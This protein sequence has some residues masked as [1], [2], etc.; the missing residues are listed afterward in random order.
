MTLEDQI[1]ALLLE[2]APLR[3][4][5]EMEQGELGAIV[6]RI[7][8]LREKQ[9]KGDDSPPITDEAIE[10]GFYV[11][12]FQ[13]PISTNPLTHA[14]GFVTQDMKDAAADDAKF[15]TERV[16]AKRGPGRPKK[17]AP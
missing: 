7:N 6:D 12:P 8:A 2:A 13:K 16:A 14:P 15:K 3:C 5:P 9:N 11:D 17:A 10:R 1:A 4:L